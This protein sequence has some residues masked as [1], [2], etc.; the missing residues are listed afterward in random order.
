MA[1]QLIKSNQKAKWKEGQERF[2]STWYVPFQAQASI[3]KAI[4]W[5]LA[6][7]PASFLP[8]SGDVTLLPKFLEAVSR[9]D[10]AQAPSRAELA[11]LIRAEEGEPLWP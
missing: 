3:D 6:D 7:Q 9:F 2:A 11:E 4:G 10:P 1:L 8:S 5:V